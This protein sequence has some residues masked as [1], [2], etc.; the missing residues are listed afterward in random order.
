MQKNV[1]EKYAREQMAKLGLHG[2]PHV[3]RV[4]RLCVQMARMMKDVDVEVL[5]AAALLHDM[6]KYV[7]KENNAVDHGRISAEMAEQFLHSIK[8][9]D[10]KVKAVCHAIRVHTHGEEP[11]SLES[12]IVHDADFLD[13]MGA[14]GVATVFVKACLANTTIEEA[15]ECWKNPSMSS[16]VGLHAFWIQKPHFYTRLARNVAKRRNKIVYAFFKQ[17]EKEMQLADF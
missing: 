1:I 4:Q 7:E 11:R 14:V 3:K 8:F 12:K 10:E 5:N 2:W 16:F 15:A 9:D 17:L 13:K 6:G